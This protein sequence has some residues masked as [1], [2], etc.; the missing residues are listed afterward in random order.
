MKPELTPEL[1]KRFFAQYYG[2]KVMKHKKTPNID[3]N[4]DLTLAES[5]YLYLKLNPIS[6]ITDQEAIEI[7]KAATNLTT[8]WNSSPNK[9]Y[10]TV[11]RDGKYKGISIT[12]KYSS[13]DVQIDPVDGE[14]TVYEDDTELS[15]SG[16]QI[17]GYQLMLSYGI[18]IPFMG[19]SVED[20]VKSGWIRLEE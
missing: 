9:K 3:F 18:A 10:F 13:R 2:Q 5:N 1:K 7:G 6:S 15:A 16:T 14:I 19:H 12:E 11:K 17:W 8:D 4:V 20:L